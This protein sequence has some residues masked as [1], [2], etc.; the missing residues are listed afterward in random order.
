MAGCNF[1]PGENPQVDEAVKYVLSES[2]TEGSLVLT[3]KSADS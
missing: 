2:L 1:Y 3:R